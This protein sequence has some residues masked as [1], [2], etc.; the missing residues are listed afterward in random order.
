MPNGTGTGLADRL[1]ALTHSLE[2]STVDVD[3]AMA[4]GLRGRRRRAAAASGALAAVAVACSAALLVGLG[5]GDGNGPRR[6][7]VVA[8]PEVT[9]PAD[10]PFQVGAEFGWL[11]GGMKAEDVYLLGW[12]TYGDA[13]WQLASSTTATDTAVYLRTMPANL[14]AEQAA[15][16]F[17][18]TP[19]PVNQAPINGRPAYWLVDTGASA[20]SAN[21][22]MIWRLP[23]GRWGA[24]EYY[25][26]PTAETMRH[27]AEGVTE[28]STPQAMPFRVTGLPKGAIV[29]GGRLWQSPGEPSDWQA[30][31]GVDYKNTYFTITVS[32]PGF[33]GLPGE[34]AADA[35]CETSNGLKAC[36]APDGAFT[37]PKQLSADGLKGLLAYVTLMGPDRRSWTTHVTDG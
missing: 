30:E 15:D 33:A 10:D 5:S 31:L 3:R 35:V 21:T 12:V 9:F 29:D 34:P 20:K 1:D 19:E 32:L 26:S 24:L 37:V 25:G 23:D 22:R 36:V 8:S 27:I 7:T 2:P 18:P 13:A 4:D 17:A 28:G 11:P 6:T 14:T 16:L